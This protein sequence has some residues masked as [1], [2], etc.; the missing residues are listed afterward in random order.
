MIYDIFSDFDVCPDNDIPNCDKKHMDG[1]PFNRG[2]LL[3]L[4]A[5]D[6]IFIVEEVRVALLFFFA[7]SIFEMVYNF[8]L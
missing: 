3:L 1:A 5:P 2:N 8:E 6:P 4:L 7:I